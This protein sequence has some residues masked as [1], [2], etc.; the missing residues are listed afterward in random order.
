M[1]NEKDI[2]N[3]PQ[4]ENDIS[5]D[6]TLVESNKEFTPEQQQKIHDLANQIEPLNYDSLMKFGSNAQSSMSQFSHKM[7]S[8]VKSKDTGPIGDT[9]NQLMLKLKE[10]QPDD[11]KEGKD[12]FI[13]KIF[14]R[15]KA[16]ANEIFSRM[17]SVG[18]QVDRIS[19]ELTNHKD[20][21]NR[22]I[23]LLNGLYDQNKDYFDELNLYIAAA[24]EKKQDILEKELPEKRKKAYESGN[25]MDIQEVADLEQFADRLDKRIYDLQLSRQISLQTAPQIRMIQNVNQT[26]AEKIQS[27][28]LTSIP[29]WKNQMAIALTLMRQRQ[30]MSAQRAVTDTTNDLLTANSE[31]LK[32]NAVDT[33][34]ENE[35]GIVDIETLKS[36]HENIIETVE[37]TLQIQAE[38]REKRQQAEKELQ[39]LES[40]MKERLLTMKDNKIQ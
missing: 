1:P 8:E 19:I 23:Q 34:V 25:Q 39:H 6:Q 4:L 22:D 18:S 27:S 16:S 36:T 40:D 33:A 38:G 28:I 24:Q 15:A 3:H 32:Q 20:S 14:K 37:Q 12:S 17:Q 5:T 30:A 21:L 10:V 26:L 29:L 2:P 9:L 31:L 11:F 13:K 7:L 35:R